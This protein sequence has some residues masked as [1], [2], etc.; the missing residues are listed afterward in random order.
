MDRRVQLSTGLAAGA[1]T[2]VFDGDGGARSCRTGL[3][4]NK[5]FPLAAE[6]SRERFPCRR[7]YCDTVKLASNGAL[8]TLAS[9]LLRADVFR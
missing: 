6:R 8:E 2:G 5:E 7:F 4:R 1:R 9:C 3:S